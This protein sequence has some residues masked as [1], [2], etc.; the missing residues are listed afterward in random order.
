MYHIVSGVSIVLCKKR[1]VSNV[2]I[3][4]QEELCYLYLSIILLFCNKKQ[5]VKKN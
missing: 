3:T 5:D 1:I 2:S 4:L